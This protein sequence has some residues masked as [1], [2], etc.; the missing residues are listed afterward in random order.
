MDRRIGIKGW[1]GVDLKTVVMGIETIV[2]LMM[3]CNYFDLIFP[4]RIGKF[5]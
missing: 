4:S 3:V 2:F 1:F 5:L